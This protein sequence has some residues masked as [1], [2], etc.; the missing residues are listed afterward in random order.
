M[1]EPC[2]IRPTHRD[3]PVLLNELP[4]PPSR[5]WITG[6]PTVLTRP[7]VAV[8]GTRRATPRGLAVSRGLGRALALR[9][10]CVVSGLALGVDAAAHVGALEAGGSTVAV[11]A[12][13]WDRTY[14]RE[15][16]GLRQRIEGAGCCVTEFEAGH[17]PRRHH[18]PRRNRIIAGLCRGV[19]VVEAPGRSG[20]LNTAQHA[21]DTGR[22]V[23]A[24]P[25]PVDLESYRGC[26]RLLRE[27]AQ[28]L[29]GPADIDRVLGR[30]PAVESMELADPDQVPD[31]GSAARWIL[32]RVDLEGMSRD[33]LRGRWP[34][35]EDMWCAGLLELE[36]GGLIRRLPGG[37]LARTLWDF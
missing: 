2:F 18:F 19:V 21:A 1:N 30:L 32:D 9:G 34:G 8:V 20:A 29:E 17:A 6:D 12:T 33:R 37:R 31:P 35:T 13:G 16:A 7:A 3:W 36:M 15:H 24:V 26:H 11:M 4:T 28:L 22:E 10:W 23:F 25:G 27:G 5:L 14:P